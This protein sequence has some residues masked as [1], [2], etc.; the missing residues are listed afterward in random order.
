MPRRDHINFLE[1][2]PD[3]SREDIHILG[4]VVPD[5]DPMSRELAQTRQTA[6]CVEGIVQYRY[7]HEVNG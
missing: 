3:T 4:M 6:H 7:I 1:L 2:V 5:N